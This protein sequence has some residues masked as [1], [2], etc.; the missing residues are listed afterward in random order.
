MFKHTNPNLRYT[1]LFLFKRKKRT[2]LSPYPFVKLKK[3]ATRAPVWL[4]ADP[5]EVLG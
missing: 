2:N 1:Q 5:V 4:T 3:K